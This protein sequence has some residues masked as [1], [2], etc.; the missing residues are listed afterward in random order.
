M[1]T[2]SY[3]EP[4]SVEQLSRCVDGLRLLRD[5]R[6][7]HPLRYHNPH[8]KQADFHTSDAPIRLFSGAN[9]SGKTEAGMAEVAAFTIGKREWLPK[10]HPNYLTPFRPPV[11]IRIIATDYPTT[12][13]GVVEPKLLK[14]FP[15]MLKDKGFTIHRHQPGAALSE[16]VHPNG[17]QIQIVTHTQFEKLRSGEGWTGHFVLI[18]EPC[19]PSAWVSSVRGLIKHRGFAAFTL[20]PA[21]T[22]VNTPWIYDEIYLRSRQ[23]NKESDV[24]VFEVSMYDNVGYGLASNED[25]ERFKRSVPEIEWASRVY[26]KFDHLH[27]PIFNLE[28]ANACHYWIEPFEI[29]P[30]WTRYIAI[31]P[32]H[33]KETY[34]SFCAVSDERTKDGGF[35]KTCYDELKVYTPADILAKMIVEKEPSVQARGGTTT[36]LIDS[37][38]KILQDPTS[39]GESFLKALRQN[40]VNCRIE[41]FEHKRGSVNEGIMALQK[42]FAPMGEPKDT[43]IKFFKKLT[44]HR[45]QF[46][47]YLWGDNNKPINKDDDFP[48]CLRAIMSA[49]PIYRDRKKEKKFDELKLQPL[50]M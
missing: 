14:W 1:L 37:F 40:G 30:K 43:N 24:E 10:D 27:G 17:S 3:A 15:E 13:R 8:Q 47:R 18:D 12:V 9:Q 11:K 22:S 50:A 48:S 38:Y 49:N 16:L 2:V 34:V 29:P 32:H 19:P 25:V 42:D 4:S 46:A 26:G 20:T 35:K 31:D 28:G 7:T 45:W 5:Y 41:S 33:K 23:F 36:V 39:G 21:L 6:N 44:G